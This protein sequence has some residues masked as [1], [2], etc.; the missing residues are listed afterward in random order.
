MELFFRKIGA[1][2]PLIILHGLYGSSDNWYSIGRALADNYEVFMIDLRNHGNSP[3]S[4]EHN[5]TIM[6][7]DLVDFLAR[8]QID[9]AAFLG[10]SMGGKTA[11]AF[12][13]KNPDKVSRMIVVDISPFEYDLAHSK[14]AILHQGIMQGMQSIEPE[15]IADRREADAMMKKFV[16]EATIRQFLLKNLKRDPKGRFYWAL[17]LPVLARNM[18]GIFSGL[19]PRNGNGPLNISHFPLLFIRGE[20][21]G[22]LNKKD[23]EAIRY[24]LPWAQIITIPKSGHWVHAEQPVAFLQEIRRFM[25]S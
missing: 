18:T 3:H 14:V 7:D 24:L 19:I 6:C 9:R 23:E 25:E 22:Y 12:G 1:G 16:S 11:L 21:S 15:K 8:N 10:H 4:P 2:D 5:Y 20:Y 13:L 17:N